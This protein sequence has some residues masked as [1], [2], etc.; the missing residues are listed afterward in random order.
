MYTIHIKQCKQ[1]FLKGVNKGQRC[2][3]HTPYGL[4]RCVGH[5]GAPE[6]YCD[7][8]LMSGKRKGQRCH[9][10]GVVSDFI[11]DGISMAVCR[12]HLKALSCRTDRPTSSSGYTFGIAEM[13]EHIASFCDTT[14]RYM[15]RL[16]SQALNRSIPKVYPPESFIS[17]Y[18]TGLYF[19]SPSFIQEMSSMKVPATL[20]LTQVREVRLVMRHMKYIDWTSQIEKWCYGEILYIHFKSPYQSYITKLLTEISKRKSKWDEKAVSRFIDSIVIYEEGGKCDVTKSIEEFK[21][22]FPALVS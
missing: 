14:S 11:L 19:L 21:N 12:M 1:I 4:E 10:I 6:R 7:A 18:S 15:L 3:R 16:V 9:N 2:T 17:D 5:L 13:G 22:R 8:Q 20:S